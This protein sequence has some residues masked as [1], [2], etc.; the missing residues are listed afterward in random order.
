MDTDLSYRSRKREDSNRH[1][2][3]T[4]YNGG[5]GMEWLSGLNDAMNYIEAHLEDEIDMQKAA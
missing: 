1:G 2:G 5:N 4:E 3:Y